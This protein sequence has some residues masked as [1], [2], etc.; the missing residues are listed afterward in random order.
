VL[1]FVV[2]MSG[3]FI[4]ISLSELHNLSNKNTTCNFY[5][6]VKLKTSV[7]SGF[8]CETCVPYIYEHEN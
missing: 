6:P 1:V 3:S 7:F 4:T 8:V 2:T 5:E